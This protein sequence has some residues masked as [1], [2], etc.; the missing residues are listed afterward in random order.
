MI[1]IPAVDIRQGNSVRLK[2]GKIDAETI[3]SKD[4]VFIA[5]LWKS[6]GAKRLHVVD[7]D[8]AFSGINTNKEIIKNICA[9]V[10]IPV[11][12]GGGIRNMEKIKEVFD[13]GATY[14]I[15]GT[16]AF[17]DPEIVKK[18]IN[19]YGPQK[20]II[21]VDAKD[22]KIAISGWKDITSVE[23]LELVNGLKEIGVQEILYTDISRDGMFTGPDFI[24]LKKLFES[25]M[26]IIASGGVKTID[27]LIRLKKYEKDGVF[28]AIVGSALYTDDFKLEDAIKKV[29]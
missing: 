28:A 7:L 27:D 16:V 4:P 25:D 21:A 22:G 17:H 26:R 6:K 15:L 23:V 18:A 3:Y 24:G 11:E 8:G 13:L 14:V 1:I 19:K 20:I 9:A 29:E 10:D 5:K 2:Q 12:V